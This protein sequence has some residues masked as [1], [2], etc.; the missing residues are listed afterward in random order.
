MRTNQSTVPYWVFAFLILLPVS[1]HAEE[2]LRTWTDQ[3]G[4]FQIEA[5][6]HEVKGNQ[7]TLHTKDGREIAVAIDV[8]SEKDQ[9]LLKKQPA[10][11][12]FGGGTMLSNKPETKP[13]PT[14]PPQE[15]LTKEAMPT[16]LPVGG[17]PIGLS[18]NSEPT[19]IAADPGPAAATFHPFSTELEKVDAYAKLSR[20]VLVEPEQALYAISVHRVGNSVSPDHFGRL[21]LA[22]PQHPEGQVV[23]DLPETLVLLDHYPATDRTLIVVGVDSPSQRGGDLVLLEGLAAGM[24]TALARWHLPEWQKPGFKPKVEYARLLD[25]EKAVVQVNSSIYVWDLQAGKSIFTMKDARPGKLQLSGGQRYLAIPNRGA[26]CVVDL[27]EGKQLCALPFSTPTTPEVAFSPD[28]TKLAM[29]AGNQYQTWNLPEASVQHEGTIAQTMG[30]FFGWLDDELL[31][32]QMGGVIDPALGASL[33][34]YTLPP[35]NETPTTQPGGVVMLNGSSTTPK[36][37]LAVEVPHAPVKAVRQK[38]ADGGDDI[39]LTRSGT[40]VALKV[41]SLPDV[42]EKIILDGLKTAVERAGWVV[43]PDAS[44]VLVAKIDRA[45]EI[46]LN[47]R[48]IGGA[49]AGAQQTARLKPYTNSLEIRHGDDILWKRHRENMV[50]RLLRIEDGETVQQAVTRY[51]R[52]DPEYFS[53][54]QIPPRILKPEVSQSIG[55]STIQDQKWRD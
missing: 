24:P 12:P 43:N 9:A 6:L 16:E 53:R 13:T 34:R 54:L 51:E 7:V 40:E 46:N 32:T 31:L 49:P 15:L 39:F 29:I 28:G 21:Y 4:K 55:R 41:E 37:M 50:P 38:L 36:S 26:V 35:G 44:I 33:W 2:E 42:D 22:S 48:F 10:A 19:A 5:R 27:K 47:F 52:A 23:L 14:G 3:T 18:I 25:S 8:L 45:D 17:Q 20:P 11:N 1:L 30:V